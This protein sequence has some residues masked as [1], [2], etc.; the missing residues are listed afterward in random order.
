VNSTHISARGFSLSHKPKVYSLL[1]RGSGAHMSAST[2]FY[3]KG[4]NRF[5]F[6]FNRV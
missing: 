1:D 3:G 5:I 2:L 6:Q 4:F